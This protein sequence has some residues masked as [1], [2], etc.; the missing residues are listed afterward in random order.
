MTVKTAA[1]NGKAVRPVLAS[2]VQ[3]ATTPNVVDT[4]AATRDGTALQ[5]VL[6]PSLRG[7]PPPPAAPAKKQTADKPVG[8]TKAAKKKRPTK[9]VGSR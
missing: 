5:A 7:G 1:R 8:A 6:A 4:L 2:G 3:L 9:K